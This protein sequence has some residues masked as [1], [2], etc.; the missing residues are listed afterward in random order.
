MKKLS[1]ALLI[2]LAATGC[3]SIISESSNHVV[4]DSSPSQ[5]EFTI[6][7]KAGLTLHAGTT[8]QTVVLEAGG[9]YFS[10]ANY[11]VDYKKEGYLLKSTALAS[12]INGWYFG[13]LLF[14][15]LIGLLIVDPATGAMWKLPER[16]EAVLE[17][18][19]D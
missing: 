8:P 3:A 9:G 6:K 15:G 5:S 12:S 1:L 13:N 14:G 11:T 2:A 18:Q 16:T 7:D 19:V 17:K 10:K 4:V